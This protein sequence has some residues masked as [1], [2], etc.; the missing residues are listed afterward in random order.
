MTTAR[1]L[2]KAVSW[3]SF[4]NIVSK[5]LSLVTMPLL[6]HW[7]S[8]AAYGDA[9]LVGTAISLASVFA[10]AGIDMS[11][12][13][14]YFSGTVG[15][16]QS[17][18]SYCWRW[19]LGMSIVLGIAVG[20][21]WAIG[22]SGRSGTEASL[23]GFVVIGVIASTLATMTQTRARLLNRYAQL[24]W[25][26]FLSA[27]LGAIVAL[28]AAHWWR[29]DAWPLLLA[30][31]I[32]YGLPVVFLGMPS[33]VRLTR[34]SGLSKDA[35]RR[36]LGVGL[37]GVITAPAYWVVS[38]SDRWFIAQYFDNAEVGIY[39]V[40]CTVGT[41]GMVVSNA[42][43]AAWLPELS[44]AES[45]DGTSLL[46]RKGELS[47]VL[48][49]VLL[50]AWL[51]VVAAGGDVIRLLADPR[52]H[53]VAAVV[54]WLAAGVLFHG[55]M[56]VGNAHLILLGKLHWAAWCWG[57]ALFVSIGLNF[58]LVPQYGILGASITQAVT[59]SMAMLLIW[60]A[61]LHFE[62]VPIQWSLL[63][64]MAGIVT[65]AGFAMHLPWSDSAL[66]SLVF[67]LPVGMAVSLLCAQF[68]APAMMR[69]AIGEVG[70]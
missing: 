23:A 32:A 11:Y 2:V 67:K 15:D 6:T 12:S 42:I 1:G 24:S 43:T 45:S 27:L 35:A 34:S 41:I 46:Q 66:L 13:R 69:R 9:A 62:P 3:L 47:Q 51:A 59:L 65:L 20:A 48:A 25:V 10:L 14:H 40:G 17:V 16:S 22:F 61:V 8:P 55:A 30:M 56:H 49:A 68:L 26:Q 53:S 19:V 7:L 18:E 21:L 28:S 44:R 70:T 5:A 57:L 60:A 31:V 50:I 63:A 33:P 58:W 4:G 52:F 54:P 29:Q 36:L 37:A 38:S 39:S 64:I